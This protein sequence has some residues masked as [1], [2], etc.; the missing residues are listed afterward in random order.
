MFFVSRSLSVSRG[1]YEG[2]G[3]ISPWLYTLLLPENRDKMSRVSGLMLVLFI[4]FAG[5]HY[6]AK[7]IEV[8]YNIDYN[9]NIIR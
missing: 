5:S 7:N 8:S 4:H 9:K 3:Q 2:R 1:P 6:D